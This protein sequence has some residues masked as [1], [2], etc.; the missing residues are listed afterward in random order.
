VPQIFKRNVKIEHTQ[1]KQQTNK[2][3]N[4]N[5]KNLQKCLKNSN[6]KISVLV[7]FGIEDRKNKKKFEKNFHFENHLSMERMTNAHKKWNWKL[8]SLAPNWLFSLS[9]IF[10]CTY[11]YRLDLAQ[12]QLL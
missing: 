9:N 10:A 6:N 2:R 12:V 3:K 7:L 11:F 1:T 4:E 8:A 5:K